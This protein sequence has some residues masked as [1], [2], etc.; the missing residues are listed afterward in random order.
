ML[1][2]EPPPF[3]Y[4]RISATERD[5]SSHPRFR[6]LDRTSNRS[7]ETIS[8]STKLTER[9][10][11]HGGDDPMAHEQERK[12][13]DNTHTHIERERGMKE[14]KMFG[15]AVESSQ[16]DD[17][18][19]DYGAMAGRSVGIWEMTTTL[20]MNTNRNRALTWS[21]SAEALEDVSFFF[22]FGMSV[23][24][25]PQPTVTQDNAAR[26][27]LCLCVTR[28]QSG[29]VGWAGSSGWATG[30]AGDGAAWGGRQRGME[31]RKD[32]SKGARK[33]KRSN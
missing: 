19:G 20:M 32:G 29:R 3:P 9:A 12:R 5:R 6:L 21:C 8:L 1:R 7:S 2:T 30:R 26:A 25:P 17:G 23:P 27:D 15:T 24:F 18:G 14:K 28:V 13:Q 22:F 16:N 4:W 11:V 33:V 31:G 10:L